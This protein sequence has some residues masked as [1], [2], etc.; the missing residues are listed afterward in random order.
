MRRE[1]P[2]H[3]L[4][5]RPSDAENPSL[6]RPHPA[7]APPFS[8]FGSSDWVSDPKKILLGSGTQNRFIRVESADVWARPE[9]EA[10]ITAAIAQAKMPLPTTGGGRLFMRSV[11]AKQKSRRK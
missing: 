7:L 5:F 2:A 9:I 10:L 8:C 4:V 3:C 11:S 6:S 1:S